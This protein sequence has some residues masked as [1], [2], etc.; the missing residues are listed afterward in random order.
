VTEFTIQLAT[1]T[2]AGI[3]IVKALA[4]LEGQTRPGPFKGVLQDLVEDVSSGTPLS[5]AMG[6]HEKVFDRLYSSMVRA[7]EAGGVLDKVLLRQ[8]AFL[9]NQATMRAKILQATIYPAVIVF[10]AVVVVAAV[11]VGIVPKF[12]EIFRSFRIELPAMTQFLLDVSDFATS[13]W[14]LVF[15][16]PVVLLFAHL[17]AMKRSRAWRLRMHALLFDCP[18][19][20]HL[21]HVDSGRR[22]ALGC[23]GHR[24][25]FHAQ[26]S[27][28]RWHRR[29]AQGRARRRGDR[30]SH[31]RNRF[32]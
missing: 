19:L 28:G 5:E 30:P 11:I 31:G 1:L 22:A 16:L 10:V 26:R 18:V 20:A 4:I 27:A 8:A 7:G 9:E 15:G 2:E 17:T 21:R 25:R 3:P 12:Q 29:C 13:Y 24:A 23:L 14:W 32:V 6:K